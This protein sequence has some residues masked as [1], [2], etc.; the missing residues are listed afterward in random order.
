L[1]YAQ[2]TKESIR[3]CGLRL[4]ARSAGLRIGDSQTNAN[5]ATKAGKMN[6]KTI[7]IP[8]PSYGCDPTEV[9][10]PWKLLAEH[11]IDVVFATPDG[12]PAVPDQKMLNGQNLG[13]FKAL[14]QTRKDAVEAF[15]Q[16]KSNPAFEAPK[17][18]SELNCGDYDGLLLPGGH[19][20]GVKE[21]LESKAL[22][23]LVV[24]FF[25]AEKPVAAICHGVVLAA[26]S[27][28]PATGKSA[29]HGY[30]TTSLLKSQEMA[31]YQLT[32][33]WL[34]DY[35]LTYPGLT[36]QDEVTAALAD[37]ANFIEGPTPV[38]RDDLKHL[39]RGFT[40]KDQN[41]VSARWP[42]DAYSFGLEFIKMLN[43]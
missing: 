14:L 18:Y 42:G 27:I 37:K 17:K 35:Y 36:V 26:R 9:A 12:N 10:I 30:K 24:E 34:K 11:G 15:G 38:L 31:A 6:K 29:I 19:D 8:L 4:S 2:T 16:M 43:A 13:V 20:K 5:V 28:D 21:Y 32:R 25:G 7:L 23:N 40:V 3:A 41:Y 22:Q 33:L 1:Y 39:Y